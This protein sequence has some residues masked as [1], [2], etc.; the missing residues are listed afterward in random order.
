MKI[1]TDGNN[2]Y[3]VGF[4][5]GDYRG[6][7]NLKP[8]NIKK[9]HIFMIPGDSKFMNK[10]DINLI[11]LYAYLCNKTKAT[12]MES[13][14]SAN[15]KIILHTFGDPANK[16]YVEEVIQ[17]EDKRFFIDSISTYF[18]HVNCLNVIEAKLENDSL[19]ITWYKDH[20]PYERIRSLSSIDEKQELV[21]SSMLLSSSK[22]KK[23]EIN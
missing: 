5:F 6:L 12:K 15:I 18:A 10:Y 8:C 7:M 13:I 22:Y 21:K 1:E 14:F 19:R 16:S 11:C 4:S 2:H 20:I 9:I 23:E 3:Y 17:G